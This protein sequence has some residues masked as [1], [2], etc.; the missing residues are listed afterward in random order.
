[1]PKVHPLANV[2]PSATLGRGTTVWESTKIR[3]DAVIGLN[4]VIGAHVYIGSRVTLG[5]NCKVQNGA[6]LHDPAKLDRGVF[7]GPGAILTNDRNPRAI[8]TTGLLKGREDWKP[9]GVQIEVGASIGANAVCVAPL[10]VG[11]WALVGAGAVVTR[12]VE[13]YSIVAGVPAT[14]VGWVGE[15]GYPL[16][17]EG[18]VLT[19]PVTLNRYQ[20][21]GKTLCPL[22]SGS[23]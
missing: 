21:Q 14:H 13:P 16:Q 6:Q 15:A 22:G 18:G 3:E 23:L 12:D 10:V 4:C 5:D 9:A 7:I 8:S 11:A 1:M 17:E 20:L 2:D 19:C